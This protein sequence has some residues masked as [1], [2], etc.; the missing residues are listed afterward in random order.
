MWLNKK[1][2]SMVSLICQLLVNMNSQ[3]MEVLRKTYTVW[4][5][6]HN[7]YILETVGEYSSNRRFHIQSGSSFNMINF[8]CIS[9]LLEAVRYIASFYCWQRV[10]HRIHVDSIHWK[11]AFG[12]RYT[13][14]TFFYIH[15]WLC[16]TWRFLVPAAAYG[17]V[18]VVYGIPPDGNPYQMR[19]EKP[20]HLQEFNAAESG[21]PG[22]PETEQTLF[23]QFAAKEL[24]SKMNSLIQIIQPTRVSQRCGDGVC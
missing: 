8:S 6:F 14:R 1:Q 9:V 10:S 19:T 12:N 3:A 17:T 5:S 20:T 22:K 7:M 16:S 23:V 24:F 13:V 4:S 11:L 21:G 2:R 18:S 15:G